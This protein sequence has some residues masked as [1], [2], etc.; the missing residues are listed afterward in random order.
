MSVSVS[1]SSR[2]DAGGVAAA[3]DRD[4]GRGDRPTPEGDA[5]RV[6]GVDLG[7]HRVGRG[8]VAARLVDQHLGAVTAARKAR[9]PARALAELR[10]QPRLPGQRLVP[11][12]ELDLREHRQ[13]QVPEGHD[14]QPERLELLEEREDPAVVADLVL[15]PRHGVEA[16]EHLE[17]VADRAR[18]LEALPVD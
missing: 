14:A 9:R 3:G 7:D 4:R 12:T 13:R 10:A 15:R 8:A 6:P 11:L 16:V 18:D 1:R 17:R 2:R 5:R